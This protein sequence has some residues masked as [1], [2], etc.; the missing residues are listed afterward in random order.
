MT[1]QQHSLI[2]P[3][4]SCILL[5]D[6]RW[7]SPITLKQPNS[8]T[9]RW[10]QAERKPSR[11][12]RWPYDR[13]HRCSSLKNSSPRHTWHQAHCRQG[14]RILSRKLRSLWHK[15]FQWNCDR[16]LWGTAAMLGTWP[17]YDCHCSLSKRGYSCTD[18]IH[19]KTLRFRIRSE[20]NL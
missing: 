10:C 19:G 16:W 4:N 17:W 1:I 20:V 7:K 9:S 14:R 2:V 13:V 6:T 5:N 8:R 15:L 18:N 12:D 11:E 3:P